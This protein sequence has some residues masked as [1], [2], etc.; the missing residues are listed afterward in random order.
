MRIP[1]CDHGS[2]GQR[3]GGEVLIVSTD[4]S[5]QRTG[6]EGVLSVISGASSQRTEM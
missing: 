1:R 3:K 4:P 6:N 2:G 5:G